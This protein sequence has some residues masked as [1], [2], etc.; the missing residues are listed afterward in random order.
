MIEPARMA[1]IKNRKTGMPVPSDSSNKKSC[2]NWI[3]AGDPTGIVVM[4]PV[5]LNANTTGTGVGTG[6]GVRAGAG[7]GVGA[8]A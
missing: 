1:T 4:L 7:A 2:S 3:R 6:A 8:G 5:R